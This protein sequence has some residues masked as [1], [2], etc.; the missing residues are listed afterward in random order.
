MKNFGG[1]KLQV[2][3]FLFCFFLI[4]ACFPS[5][6]KAFLGLLSPEH[7]VETAA[8]K[9]ICI[10]KENILCERTTANFDGYTIDCKAAGTIKDLA[11]NKNH[12]TSDNDDRAYLFYSDN[13]ARVACYHSHEWMIRRHW[14]GIGKISSPTCS[15]A[16]H[17]DRLK[18]L[19]A[20]LDPEFKR[21]VSMKKWKKRGEDVLFC[22]EPG[23]TNWDNSNEEH[24]YYVL[25]YNEAEK[26]LYELIKNESGEP[27]RV[28]WKNFKDMIFE[29]M[30]I[31]K[32]GE[33]YQHSVFHPSSIL[34]NTE[35]GDVPRRKGKYSRRDVTKCLYQKYVELESLRF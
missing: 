17:F 25:A 7:C 10:K 16:F 34:V 28:E 26:R 8:G 13:G 32:D 29:D 22:Y 18:G 35:W 12:W 4:S 19:M 9:K 27:E 33:S 31:T 6:S 15:A 23:R 11:G 20:P 14:Q 21:A 5:Q 24:I 1:T 30:F 3:L 2:N